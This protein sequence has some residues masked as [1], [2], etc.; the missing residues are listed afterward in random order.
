M[1]AFAQYARY[2]HRLPLRD[3]AV[4]DPTAPTGSVFRWNTQS[5]TDA[6]P[7]VVGDW[8][9]RPARR[10][11]A[12]TA[13]PP[14][15]RSIPTSASRI[16][17]SSSRIRVAAQPV[18]V[19]AA[20]GDRPPRAPS[21]SVSSTS[22]CRHRPT[23]SIGIPDTGVDRGRIAGMTRRSFFFNR[24]PATFG[25]D[26]Y[27]LTNP[28]GDD[29]SFVGADLIGA[30]PVQARVLPVRDSRRDDRKGWSANRG[31]GAARERRRRCS[32]RCYD[33]SERARHRAGTRSSPSAAT[34]SSIAR[35]LPA[36]GHD[37]DFG[38]V[39]A[40]SGRPALRAPGDHAR[41]EP[42]RRSGARV[43]ATAAPASRSR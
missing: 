1:A 37:I 33:E 11:R 42:G 31:F 30:D 17:T 39:G 24:S 28:A 2:G 7:A 25:Q 20:R 14:S 3:L 38:L 6:A 40:L 43:P 16:C 32:A 5:A 21:A 34:R 12:S 26:R 15:A 8:T 4:G 9:A 36:S 27:L 35:G 19:P 22:A 13:T 29:T 41:A 18:D 23:P 10:T